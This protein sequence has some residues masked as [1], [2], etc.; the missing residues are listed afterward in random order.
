MSSSPRS[1]ICRLDTLSLLEFEENF[2]HS[3]IGS[4]P[5]FNTSLGADVVTRSGAGIRETTSRITFLVCQE[6]QMEMQATQLGK[7]WG[8]LANRVIEAML[9]FSST[10]TMYKKPPPLISNP[11]S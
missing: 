4:R 10:K 5:V 1:L 6:D 8:I 3:Q 9:N 7:N 11:Y 2:E